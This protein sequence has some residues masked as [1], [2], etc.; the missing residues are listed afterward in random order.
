[1]KTDHA[2]KIELVKSLHA[3]LVIGTEGNR[4]LSSLLLTFQVNRPVKQFIYRVFSS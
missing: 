3:M 2:Y 1:M 4:K